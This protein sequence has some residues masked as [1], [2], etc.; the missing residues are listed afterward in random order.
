M[1]QNLDYAIYSTCCENPAL[2]TFLL[3]SDDQAYPDQPSFTVEGPVGGPRTGDIVYPMI[4]FP[5]E[6]FAFR[7]DPRGGSATPNN[8]PQ[9]VYM[10]Y[11]TGAYRRTITDILQLW[12]INS[13][14]NPSWSNIDTFP[15]PMA[16]Y[17]AMAA[18]EG[19]RIVLLANGGLNYAVVNI[20][21]EIS[22]TFG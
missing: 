15:Q 3:F 1:S 20:S 12:E 14:N 18:A 16:S 13:T 10:S 21:K 9:S 4:G 7:L 17:N 11:P 8:T 22:N 19:Q 6:N 2:F 5:V